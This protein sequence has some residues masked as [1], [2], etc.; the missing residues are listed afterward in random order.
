MTTYTNKSLEK[1]NMELQ[2]WANPQYWRRECLDVISIPI[3]EDADILEDKVLKIFGKLRCDIPPERIKACHRISKNSSIVIVKFTKSKDYQQVWSVKRD[4]QKIK[5]RDVN[6]LSANFTKWSNTLK[7]FFGFC[8]RT[9]S[10]CLII[11][12]DW[13]LKG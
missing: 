9:V 10:A 7:Q 2:C 12:W 4:L 8:R 6:P 11:L 13:R 3:D 1:T 5:M